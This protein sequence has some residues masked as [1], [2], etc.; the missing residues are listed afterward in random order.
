MAFIAK[1][2]YS[3]VLSEIISEL[4]SFNIR[5]NKFSVSTLAE[6]LKI[7]ISVNLFFEKKK[8]IFYYV[9]GL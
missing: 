6:I 5:I 8:L 3:V 2:I 1:I 7:F 9:T 4:I